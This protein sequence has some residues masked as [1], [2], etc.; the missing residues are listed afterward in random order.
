MIV[1]AGWLE[2]MIRGGTLENKEEIRVCHLI[3]Q[4]WHINWQQ[5]TWYN[6]KNGGNIFENYQKNRVLQNPPKLPK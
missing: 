4:S 1:V 3:C 2:K 5:V 6:N